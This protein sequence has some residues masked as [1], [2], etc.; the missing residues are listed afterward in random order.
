MEAR[1][2]QKRLISDLPRIFPHEKV[3]IEWDSVKY[4]PH[5]SNHK[6]VYAPRIDIAVGPFNDY[7]ELDVGTDKTKRMQYHPFTKKLIQNK[8]ERGLTLRRLWNSYSRCFAAI[9]I[10]FS[11]TSKHILGSMINASVTGSVGIIITNKTKYE[12]TNRIFNYFLR[13]E[14]LER[15]KLNTLGNIFIFEEEEFLTF[16]SVFSSQ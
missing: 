5:I 15:M 3:E 2:Y 10:E 9:E 7:F 13:L 4:D 12:V 1:E 8:L 16:L 11:G 6:D 14:S